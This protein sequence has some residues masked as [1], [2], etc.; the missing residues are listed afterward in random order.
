MAEVK[1]F[2]FTPI[3][4][5]SSSRY[6]LFSICKRRYFYQYYTKYDQEV[7]TRKINQ[8]RELVSIP[9]ETG[10]IV[11]KIIEVLLTRLKRT[12]REID[13]EKFF[14][15]ARRMAENHLRTRKFEEVIYGAMAQV[16]ADAVYPKVRESLLNLL[17]SDRLDWLVKEAI[18]NSNEWIIDPPGYGETRVRDLKVYCKVDF[19][20]PVGGEYH[21]VDWK[22]GK[23]DVE[24]HRKQL[25]GYSTWAS[26]HFDTDPTNVKP[27]IVYLHPEY[28]EVQ[29][30]FNVFDLENFAIQVQAETEEMYEYCRDIEQNIPL[31]KAEFPMIDDQR[32]CAYCNFRGICYAN[33]YPANLSA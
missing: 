4:G 23:P 25:I 8:L 13:A 3:L 7:Q 18:S 26:Y 21:I 32:I 14:D 1:K 27:N 31:D 9:L 29:E 6:D 22:T 28:H 15:F 10:G 16:E 33:L 20:F 24:K 2:P 19:L 11:H 12:S 30:T 17:A 5:W